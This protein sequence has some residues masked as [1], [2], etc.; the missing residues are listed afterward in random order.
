[1]D[2]I[3][4]PPGSRSVTLESMRSITCPA[5]VAPLLL[6][7][8]CS[9]AARIDGDPSYHYDRFEVRSI[10][11]TVSEPRPNDVFGN[12]TKLELAHDQRSFYVLDY[13]ENT[14][15]RVDLEGVVQA[16]MGGT[17]GGPGELDRVSAIKASPDGVWVLDGG[18]RA[19]LFGP[20]GDELA[21]LGFEGTWTP[22]I[23]PTTDGL[24]LPTIRLP[25]NDGGGLLLSHVTSGGQGAI[26]TV[27]VDLPDGMVDRD[28]MNLVN[29]MGNWTVAGVSDHE[30]AIVTNDGRLD[31]WRVAVDSG[32]RQVTEIKP[33]GIPEGIVKFVRSIESPAPGMTLMAV[34]GMRAVG[35]R[36]WVGTP[37]L[38]ADLLAFSVP[39]SV[40]DRVDLVYPGV[41][42]EWWVRD[43]IVLRDRVIAITGTEVH[44]ASVEP[45]DG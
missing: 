27:G 19:V 31:G 42:T 39:D 44:I 18:G 16:T 43:A 3:H 20:D 13:S 22:D 21:V 4:S 9:E 38:G 14:I 28:L 33:L 41:L 24:I 8:G 32:Y 34:S 10:I 36:L 12:L 7:A 35:A 1:M 37:G 23:V 25:R 15:H 40:G 17:G 11:T 5:L 6:V 30:F 2:S 26:E 29:R 45:L